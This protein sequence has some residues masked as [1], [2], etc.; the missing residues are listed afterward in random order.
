MD[1]PHHSTDADYEIIHT[2][3]TLT[4]TRSD[5]PQTRNDLPRKVPPKMATTTKSTNNPGPPILPPPPT[6]LR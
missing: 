2:E 3:R 4:L 5:P 6:L 1:S